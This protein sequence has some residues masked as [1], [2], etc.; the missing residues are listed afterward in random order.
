[1]RLHPTARFIEDY[2]RLPEHLQQRADRA[3]SLLL[4][5][6]RHPS[7]RAKKMQG[8]RDPGGRDIWEG[9][10]TQAYRFTFVIAGDSYILRHVGPHEDV[11]RNP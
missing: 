8:Q 10:V 6:F 7:L 3:L 4:S 11:L 2:E 1:M 9:R 5:N